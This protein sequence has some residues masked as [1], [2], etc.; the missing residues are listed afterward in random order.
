V[1]RILK[2]RTRKVGRGE[3]Q[4]VLVKW[5][6]YTKPTWEPLASLNDTAAMDAFEA[7]RGGNVT[8]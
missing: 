2:A 7:Q 3:R 5:S 8:G 4:E 6:G 1:E